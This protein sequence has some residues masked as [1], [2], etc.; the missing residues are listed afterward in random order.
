MYEPDVQRIVD[1]AVKKTEFLERWP[2]RYFILAAFAG[3][4]LGLGITLIFSVGGPFASEGAAALK[5]V[6]GVSFG[7]ALTLVIFAG[8]ELFT[9]NNMIGVIGGL[10]RQLTWGQ[11]GALFAWSLLGNLLGSLAV[12]WLVVQ[13]GVV[14]AMLQPTL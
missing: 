12:A 7:I 8:S 1:T 9:G 6:M 14:A 5:L 3:A 11:V 2:L 4:Y 10:A 13:S